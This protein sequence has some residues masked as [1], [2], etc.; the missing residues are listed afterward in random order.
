MGCQIGSL[1]YNYAYLLKNGRKEAD[2]LLCKLS[3]LVTAQPIIEGY[4]PVGTLIS[5]PAVNACGLTNSEV[6]FAPYDLSLPTDF[7]I[8]VFNYNGNPIIPPASE[9]SITD[10]M[11]DIVAALS[12]ASGV[13][14]SYTQISD[15]EFLLCAPYTQNGDTVELNITVS[16]ETILGAIRMNA[17]LEGGVAP[18]TPEYQTAGM[19][20]ITETQY[21]SMVELDC[22]M[23]NGICCNDIPKPTPVVC[24]SDSVS[25]ESN[26]ELREDNDLEL[27]EEAN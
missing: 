5:T 11:D 7:T 14:W 1:T 15:F 2:S 25:G 12:S 10:M 18:D 16:Q 9:T 21:N 20:C 17:E 4:I 3:W 19:N 23:K 24:E 6:G 26:I 8:T 22:W 27:R 13:Q